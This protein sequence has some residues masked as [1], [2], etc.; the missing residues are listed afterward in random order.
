MRFRGFRKRN[1]SFKRSPEESGRWQVPWGK[2]IYLTILTLLVIGLFNMV[3]RKLLYIEGLGILDAERIQ[4]EGNLTGRITSIKCWINGRISRG[5]LLVTLNQPELEQTF[6]TKELDL[7]NELQLL[8]KEKDNQVKEV[9]A[10]R[11][12]YLRAK[13]LKDLKAVT[14]TEYFEIDR[15]LK[16]AERELSLL[17]TR[18]SLARKRLGSLRQEYFDRSNG[19]SGNG[20][21]GKFLKETAIYAP[22]NGMVTLIHK[23]EGEVARVGEPILEIANLSNAFIRAHFKGSDEKE[24]IA[25]EE[26]SIYFENG[27]NTTGRITRVYPATLPL[28]LE[29]LRQYERQ[30]RYIIA[31]ILPI[32]GNL[33]PAILETRARVRLRRSWL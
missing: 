6:A 14:L 31:E 9:D 3:S 27:E 5:E 28:P 13:T 21:P 8:E 19:S 2:Y 22:E 11:Q 30:E 33:W 10:L 18:S 1:E 4:V 26:V 15:E 32:D 23:R 16:R 7:E 25:G 29:F 12:E 17:R 20:Y 24:I